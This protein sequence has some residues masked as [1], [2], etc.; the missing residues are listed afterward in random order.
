[1]N[2]MNI[3]RNILGFLRNCSHS[4]CE[5]Y[6]HLSECFIEHFVEHFSEHF[7]HKNEHL[8]ERSQFDCKVNF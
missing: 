6:F 7:W 3:E 5:H 1:M 8:C 4:W 2:A